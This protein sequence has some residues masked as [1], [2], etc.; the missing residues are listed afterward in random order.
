ME[1]SPLVP[2]ICDKQVW[3]GIWQLQV[4]PKIKNFLWRACRNA[5]PTKQALMKR[6]ITADLI[7]KRCLSVVEET[8]HAFWL[9]PE[10]EVVWGDYEEWCFR[11]EVEFK[12]VKELLSW[13]IAEGKSLDLFAYTAWMV[14]NQRNKARV[15]QQAVLRHQV[16]EQA[17]QMLAQFKANL[18]NTKVQV[19]DSSNGG[20]RWRSPQAGLVKINFD[21][22]VFNEF[23][24]SGTG[25][26]IHDNNG[27]VL[28]SCLEKI[29]QAYMPEEIEALAALKA[30]SFAL[31]LG[32]QSAILERDSLGLI[33]ALKAVKCCLSPTGLLIEDMKRVANSYVRLLYSHVKKNG[34]RVAHNLAKNALHIL[35]FRVWMED[36]SSHIVSILQ[37]DVVDSN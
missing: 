33:K 12:D 3:K 28:A 1:A 8:E 21:V 36:V 14:W 2:P 6:K 24:K 7:Y 23:N 30:V 32:F 19:T 13:L 25:V 4:P 27:V 35:D 29:H 18:Q 11:S 34:N 26:V 15:N 20:S 16:A 10:L 9:C 17:K 22:A 31:E 37:L 5:L